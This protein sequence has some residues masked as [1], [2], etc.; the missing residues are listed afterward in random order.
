MHEEEYTP[1]PDEKRFITKEEAR[2]N[3]EH[4]RQEF[5]CP[6]CG[7]YNTGQSTYTDYCNSCGWSQ[8]Y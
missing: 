4:H 1:E 3:N 7:S 2:P 8:G 5:P 6:D